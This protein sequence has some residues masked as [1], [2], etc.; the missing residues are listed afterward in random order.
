MLNYDGKRPGV[1]AFQCNDGGARWAGF[2]GFAAPPDNAQLVLALLNLYVRT[3][4]PDYHLASLAYMKWLINIQ[5]SDG[6]WVEMYSETNFDDGDAPSPPSMPVEPGWT[7]G[8][9][10]YLISAFYER[11][12]EPIQNW[13][14]ALDFM[15]RI[16]WDER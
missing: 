13:F 2:V 6:S 9:C 14:E 3:K 12:E 7:A 8:N 11:F 1:G 15:N 16:W 10:G 5:G 4:N